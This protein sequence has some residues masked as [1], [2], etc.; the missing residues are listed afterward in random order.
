M[1]KKLDHHF[2]TI[3]TKLSLVF[4]V[5]TI[6]SYIA[7]NVFEVYNY[8]YACIIGTAFSL[9]SFILNKLGYNVVARVVLL[10]TFCSLVFFYSMVY[11]D[12]STLEFFFI[13][14][15][16]MLFFV[17]SY[18]H[19][20]I[21]IILFSS[22]LLL[23]W[24]ILYF[25]NFSLFELEQVT[26]NQTKYIYVI[27]VFSLLTI[28]VF[29]LFES[30]K[31]QSKY[32]QKI[33]TIKREALKSSEE[34]IAFLNTM[35]HEIRTPLNAINGL[36]FIL[37]N[38]KPEAYQIKAINELEKNGNKLIKLLNKVL[39][40]SKYQA[41]TVELDTTP[42]DIHTKI[43]ENTLIY[44]KECEEKNI[45]F[46]LFID[47]NIPPVFIDVKKF[48]NVLDYLFYNALK[49]TTSG[50]IFLKI[51]KIKTNIHNKTNL[52]ISLIDTGLGLSARKKEEILDNE[53]NF[54]KLI[55]NNHKIG[56]GIPLTKHILSL[57]NSQIYVESKLGLGST[58]SFKLNLDNAA[59]QPVKSAST[60]NSVQK[61][62]VV[63]DN[64]VNLLVAKQILEKENFHVTEAS[65]GKE[66][67]DK[68]STTSFDLVLMDIQMPVLNGFE[69]TERIR[70]FDKKTPI[71]ALSASVLSD[72]KEEIKFYGFNGLI[73][74][75]FDPKKLIETLKTTI[76]NE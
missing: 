33:K 74:K 22:L 45:D 21:F 41:Y 75:P 31:I 76:N 10:L 12:K 40:F 50:S 16:G 30:M 8:A 63:D 20:K 18:E 52:E 65:N 48:M 49:F 13:P 37:K 55:K 71:F 54:Y 5:L 29:Q 60:E 61:I 70:E 69:A 72:L 59:V 44:K 38:E 14:L 62:L 24:C 26:E 23:E 35:S 57:M 66:A 39:D 36:A 58:F 25:T 3:T 34:K 9:L 51:Q 17:F 32:F 7:L 19:E 11:G 6:G 68:M 1:T 46:K 15:L 27:C 2:T 4:V 64:H 73:L 42:C 67:L 43:I 28:V 47:K 56:L 53:N